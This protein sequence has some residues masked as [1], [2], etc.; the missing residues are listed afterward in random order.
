MFHISLDPA[1]GWRKVGS[2]WARGTCFDKEGSRLSAMDIA[3]RLSGV[4]SLDEFAERVQD[5]N[6]FYAVVVIVNDMLVA[7]VDRIRSIP[8]FW[9][10]AGNEVYLSDSSYWVADQFD[11]ERY[12]EVCKREFVLTGYVTGYDTL[13]PNVKQLQAGEMLMCNATT[14]DLV[15]SRQRYFRL[16]EG[17]P[18]EA[19]SMNLL[20]QLDEAVISCF[21]RLVSYCDGRPVAVPLSGGYDSRLIACT[22]K[23]LGY[24]NVVAYTYGQP[25]NRDSTISKEVARNLEIGWHSVEY[26]NDRW[27]RWFRSDECESYMRIGHALTSIPHL[28]DWPAVMELTNRKLLTPDTVIVPGH[29]VASI[30]QGRLTSIAQ[31]GEFRTTESIVDLIVSSSYNLWPLTQQDTRYLD[32]FRDR[33]RRAIGDCGESMQNAAV[34][35]IQRWAW[36]EREA[37]FIANWTRVYDFWGYDWWLP[38][39]DQELIEFW[40]HVPLGFRVGRRLYDEY[41]CKVYSQ[42]VGISDKQAAKSDKTDVVSLARRWLAG[43]WLYVP[44]RAL[45]D[46]VK[47]R[48]EFDSQPR[49]SYG[50]VGRETFSRY[51]T[52]RQTSNSFMS[53]YMVGD[54]RFDESDGLTRCWPFART[55]K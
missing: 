46:R 20:E 32:I 36:Q 44:A 55:S 31:E 19:T 18:C 6:G 16:Q 11:S 15:C 22:L 48:K 33:V 13:H 17:M 41:V 37:K 42:L 23:R 39:W 53:R 5:A 40:M 26:S 54:M 43:S 14:T 47:V 8:L 49:A 1:Y 21:E 27:Y 34:D 29:S 35:A 10:R 50:K 7:A 9:G 4:A 28:Q 51:Y 45:N 25:G 24:R 52:G 38:L 12:D 2:V 30:S 3:E